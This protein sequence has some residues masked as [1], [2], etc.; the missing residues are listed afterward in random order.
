MDFW[1]QVLSLAEQEKSSL[2]EKLQQT[3]HEASS[4][5]LEYERLKRDALAHQEQDKNTI[6]KLQDELREFREQF[7]ETM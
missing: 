2:Q 4:A 7:E 3:Q 6:T 1:L 5:H